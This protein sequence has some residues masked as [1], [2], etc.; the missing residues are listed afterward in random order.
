MKGCSDGEYKVYMLHNVGSRRIGELSEGNEDDK[1][2]KFV[3][4]PEGIEVG[5]L[6]IND[7]FGSAVYMLEADKIAATAFHLEDIFG[8]Y[9]IASESRFV[10]SQWED[11][12]VDWGSFRVYDR[13]QPG[14]VDERAAEMADHNAETGKSVDGEKEKNGG[15]NEE[16]KEET[17][18]RVCPGIGEAEDP[19][20]QPEV[21]ATQTAAA[22]D[23]SPY[24]TAWE[25]QWQQFCAR[26]S[27]ICPFDEVQNIYAVKLDLRDL[28]NLPRQYRALANNSF[29]LHGYF[30]YRYLL[31]GCEDGE[32]QRWFIAVPGVFQ[33][34][35]QMMAGIFGFTGFR[36]KQVTKQKT[37]E[38]GYWYR[39]LEM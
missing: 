12:E 38:F 35:E 5:L 39:Y 15:D 25:K 18:A 2:G 34:Q 29:L 22:M 24:L 11:G 10:A 3:W 14:H 7:G 20:P 19:N 36:T 27:V 13:K 37:G 26:H 1:T 32:K 30:N 21:Q 4:E 8:I 31:F 6:R 16:G 23:I 33:N 9:L 17:G 28:R